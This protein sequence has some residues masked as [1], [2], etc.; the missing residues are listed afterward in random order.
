MEQSFFSKKPHMNPVVEAQLAEFT[1]SHPI[2]NSNEAERFEMFSIYSVTN[3]ILRENVD[4]FKIHLRGSEFGLDGL[5]ILI[6]GECCIDTDEVSEALIAGKKPSVEFVFYQSKTSEKLDYGQMSKFFDAVYNFFKHN[7][8]DE[9]E[10]LKDLFEAKNAV[11][12][13]TLKKNPT[14]QCIF[15]TT[16][17][18]TISPRIQELIDR[19]MSL[20]QEQNLF[21][22]IEITVI[23]AK[24]LQE[25]YRTSTNSISTT[26][27][28]PKAQ[29]LPDHAS[30]NEAYIGYIDA[31][32]LLKLITRESES[33]DHILNRSVFLIIYETLMMPPILTNLSQ[34]KSI[35]AKPHRSFSKTMA[36]PW[37]H[38]IS[39][40]PGT[41]FAL[42]ITKSSM[43]VRLAI[44]CSG[45]RNKLMEYLF[46]F[47]LL[48][49]M[50]KISFPV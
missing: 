32:E 34:T 38:K 33:G 22:S 12:K 27:N 39:T 37:Y 16:G 50:I 29:T 6:Q 35:V 47:G 17:T 14:I 24:E 36:S 23:G 40:E 21:D 43:D 11:Y 7:S 41:N 8:A 5:G 15:I 46:L 42:T 4:P 10:Q 44:F 2:D 1:K 9:S 31:R 30:V 49:V 20:L 19:N 45:V 28:F 48:V 13:S 18:G 26:I 25:A 3:G